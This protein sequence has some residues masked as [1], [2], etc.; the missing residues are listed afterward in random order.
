M[1]TTDK[2]RLLIY[3]RDDTRHFSDSEI[4]AFYE[5]AD[6][7]IFLAAALALEAWAT[8]E[9]STVDTEKIGDYS[10]SRKSVSNKLE[11]AARYRKQAEDAA[12]DAKTAPAFAIASLNLT[13]EDSEEGVE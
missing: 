2:I 9:A 4:N 10:Y 5:L 12:E 1:I 11:L 3:D 13:D 7:S 8:S 6:S